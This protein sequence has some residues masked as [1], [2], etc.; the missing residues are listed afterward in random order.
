MN[1]QST[2]QGCGT[3]ICGRYRRM[4][5]GTEKMLDLYLRQA[6]YMWCQQEHLANMTQCYLDACKKKDDTIMANDPT[7]TT[8]GIPH[9]ETAARTLGPD[10]V[11]RPDAASTKTPQN[12]LGSK[13]V[14]N[15]DDMT[16]TTPTGNHG[17]AIMSCSPYAHLGFA[18]ICTLH[19][20]WPPA[21]LG[22]L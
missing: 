4:C 13:R 12:A 5:A 15:T 21:V 20:T 9:T 1:K 3:R 6:L 17:G 16:T 19:R 14:G 8:D 10:L 22:T 18:E 2:T 7:N 11:G